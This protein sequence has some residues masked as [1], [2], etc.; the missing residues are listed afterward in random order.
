M[1]QNEFELIKRVKQGD[2]AAMEVIFQTH[3]EAAVRLAYMLTKDWS[4][5][6]DAVQEAFI[7]AFRSI[8][9]FQ[10]DKPFKPWFSRIVVNK[11]KRIK[12]KFRV[13]S[14]YIPHNVANDFSLSPEDQV[15]ENEKTDLIYEAI[16]QLDENH[17]L[18]IILKYV[19]ELKEIEVATIMDL[20]LSTIKSRL[21]VAR[22]RL[23]KIIK[24]K[25]RGEQ[26]A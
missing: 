5:A 6:E 22:K 15:I 23:Q 13:D 2:L 16:N 10:T 7:Q 9:S 21:Y 19:S 26:G 24:S 14:D 25:E 18:P 12:D 3:V 4:T 1:A 20:P 8:N 11:A 17:R